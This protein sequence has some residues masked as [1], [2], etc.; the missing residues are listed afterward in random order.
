MTFMIGEDVNLLRRILLVW[1]MSKFLA[2]GWD[3][4]TLHLI[5]R[6]S[7]KSWRKGG[8]S[9]PGGGNK[10]TSKRGNFLS[11]SGYMGHNYGKQF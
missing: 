1:K 7:H 10:A 3:S 6:V 2:V 9:K 4:P 8:L 5:P 11:E